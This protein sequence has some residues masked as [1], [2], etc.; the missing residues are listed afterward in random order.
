LEQNRLVDSLQNAK[1][2]NSLK[3]F[4]PTG[5]NLYSGDE[6]IPIGK[7]QTMKVLVFSVKDLTLL[8]GS[9]GA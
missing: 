1:E 2:F 5:F 4:I 7:T 6:S 3:N 9:L 8:Q